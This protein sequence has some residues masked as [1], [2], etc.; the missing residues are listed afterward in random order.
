MKQLKKPSWTRLR[1][2]R[3]EGRSGA[4]RDE[5]GAVLVLALLFVLVV[6]IVVGSIASWATNDLGNTTKFTNARTVQ[7]SVSSTVNTAIGNIRYT[8]LFATQLQTTPPNPPNYCWIPSSGSTSTLQINGVTTTVWCSTV[9]NAGSSNTRVVTFSACTT[10]NEPAASCAANPTLQAV[11]TFDD[12]PPGYS[13]P[14][15]A[16]CVVYCGTGMT[17]NSWTWN[18][19]AVIPAATPTTSTTTSTTT[20]T[21]TVPPT[22]T[23]TT[24][25]LPPTTTTTTTTPRSNGVTASPSNSN[26]NYN[27]GQEILALTNPSSITAM[28]ITINVAKTTGVSYNGMFNSFAGGALSQGNTTSGGYITYTFSLNGGQVIPA[29]TSGEVGV[30]WNGTG[31]FRVTSGDLWT[32]TSTSGGVNST[33]S[34]TF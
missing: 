10:A 29:N 22:T 2:E 26:Y 19:S 8:P 21:T 1:V 9:Y 28:T 24:T 13:P 7:Y 4:R 15:T 31:F 34:G 32:V 16:Q 27:G 17:E 25:T 20:T 6:S 30:Q 5:A 14:S 11:V 18:G 33:I 12:Y 23:T 3:Q